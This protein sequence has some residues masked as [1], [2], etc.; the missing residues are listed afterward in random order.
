MID[1]INKIKQFQMTMTKQI[2][3]AKKGIVDLKKETSEVK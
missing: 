1:K 2:E 3:E